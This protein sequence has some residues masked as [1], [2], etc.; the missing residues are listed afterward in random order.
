M[1]PG[2]PELIT[3]CQ[4]VVEGCLSMVRGELLIV[5]SDDDHRDLGQAL[6][7]AATS[8]GGRGELVLLES[9]GQRPFA[10][11]P[12]AL[13]ARLDVAQCSVL[14]I[15][16]SRHP[17]LVIR[18][19]MVEL[20]MK[21]SLRHAHM[22]G[23][24]RRALIAGFSADP[25][26]VAEST[27]AIRAK[28]LPSSKLHLRSAIGSDLHVELSP[29]YRCDVHAGIIR[30]GHWEN[31]PS[32][33]IVVHPA[34]V[35]GTYVA[36]GSL[37]GRFGGHDGLLGAKTLRFEIQNGTCRSVRCPDPSLARA[38]E[39]HLA[40]EPML[41]QV[42]LAIV[43]T[44]RGLS[45]PMGELL[46]DQCVPGVHLTFGFTQASVTGATWCSRGILTVTAGRADVDL[47]GVAL[48]RGGRLLS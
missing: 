11:M 44:N 45:S 47:D 18:R 17:D 9:L 43:G 10:T 21:S 12:P 42:G 1:F 31:L 46:H 4:R 32:G 13:R 3:A 29:A 19:E 33:M 15:G 27:R 14:L 41:N 26:R 23:L 16:I 24:S 28:I 2:D 25:A 34:M 20:A 8:L 40:S 30:S 38:I 39:Q 6:V 35:N 37:L 5:I 48:I 7:D 22:I 36:D